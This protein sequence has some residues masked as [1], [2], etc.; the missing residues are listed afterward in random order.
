MR[1]VF[2]R[3]LVSGKLPPVGEGDQSLWIRAFGIVTAYIGIFHLQMARHN[4]TPMFEI[5]AIGRTLILPALH[6]ALYLRG[7]VSIAWL[8][9]AIPSDFVAACH[10]L[11]ALRRDRLLR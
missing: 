7:E 3:I 1:Q 9:A 4:L 2:N 10:M 11:W 6:V 8:E 5:S